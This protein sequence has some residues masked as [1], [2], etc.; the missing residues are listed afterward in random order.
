MI[1][2]LLN[3]V[4]DH[5]P[6]GGSRIAAHSIMLPISKKEILEKYV[7]YMCVVEEKG[8]LGITHLNYI[9]AIVL[10]VGNAM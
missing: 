5:G 9:Y 10:M 4:I 7:H 2:S 3:V 8:L 1:D 6:A